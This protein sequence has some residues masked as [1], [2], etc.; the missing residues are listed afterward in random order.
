M[1]SIGINA[2]RPTDVKTNLELLV[3]GYHIPLSM[4]ETNIRI[5]FQPQHVNTALPILVM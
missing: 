5:V 4:W 3:L 2:Q 1:G